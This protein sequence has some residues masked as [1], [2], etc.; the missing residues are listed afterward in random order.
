MVVDAIEQSLQITT[1][2]ALQITTEQS[3]PIPTS[4]DCAEIFKAGYSSN[5][6]YNVYVPDIERSVEVYCDMTTDGGGWTVG[7]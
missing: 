7:I 1:E 2:Q 3:L 4:R 5:G 6:V